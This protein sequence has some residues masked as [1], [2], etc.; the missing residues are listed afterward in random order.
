VCSILF[1]FSLLIDAHCSKNFDNY[2]FRHIKA[3]KTYPDL[4]TDKVICMEYLPGIKITDFERLQ[5]AGLDPV[6]ISIKSANAFLEQL[7]RHG[8]FVSATEPWRKGY[9]RPEVLL[10]YT[11]RSRFSIAAL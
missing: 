2:K 1:V 9:C 7:C 10:S 8:F 3:P 6:D 5:E 4:T 11:L